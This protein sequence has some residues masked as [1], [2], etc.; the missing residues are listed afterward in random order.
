MD[1]FVSKKGG[2]GD[3]RRARGQQLFY[4]GLA[5]LDNV[6]GLEDFLGV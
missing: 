6:P 4:T 5:I 1:T 2:G 3:Q